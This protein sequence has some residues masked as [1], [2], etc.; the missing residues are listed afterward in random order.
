[1]S[2]EFDKT[3]RP[4]QV[5]AAY[6]LWVSSAVISVFSGLIF[7]TQNRESIAAKLAADATAADVDTQLELLRVIGG[8]S[9]VLGLIVGAFA[10]VMRKGDARARRALLAISACFGPIQIAIGVLLTGAGVLIGALMIAAAYLAFR[11][12]AKPWFE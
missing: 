11:P 2:P 12:S 7:I 3:T 4:S 10:G 8:I 5:T 1:M 6:W 9:I